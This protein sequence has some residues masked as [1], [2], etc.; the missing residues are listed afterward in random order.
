MTA[1]NELESVK[2]SLERIAKS[3]AEAAKW[4]AESDAWRAESDVWRARADAWH[5]VA[6]KEIAKAAKARREM[7]K[8]IGGITNTRGDAT[9]AF[10]LQALDKERRLGD[11]EFGYVRPNVKAFDR[12]QEVEF[13]ILMMNGEV[14]AVIEVK[15][16]LRCEDVERMREWTLPSFRR[17]MREYDDKTLAPAMA[18]IIAQRNALELAHQYGYAVL[19]PA[20]QRVCADV[21]HLRC[22]PRRR[23]TARS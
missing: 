10:F 20:G 12:G 18:C 6:K 13:D 7:Y 2:Q 3:N 22:L 5:A 19:R 8:E 16:K 17:L 4:R 23:A 11:L 1:M 21:S 15:H 9:E 14:V